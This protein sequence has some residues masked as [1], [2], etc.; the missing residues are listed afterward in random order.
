MEYP[1]DH[2]SYSAISKYLRCPRQWY[3]DYVVAPQEKKEVFVLLLGT[4]YHDALENLYLTGKYQEGIDIILAL[5]EKSSGFEHTHIDKTVTCYKN[6]YRSIYP[7]YQTRVQKVELKDN[8]D[9]AGVK[10]PLEYR[11]DLVTTDGV[12]VDHKTVGQRAP[13]IRYSFQFDLYSYAYFKEYGVMPRKVEYHC[14]YKS[15][16][17]VEVK[18]HIPTISN[19]LKAVDTVVGVASA[20]ENDEVYPKA[21]KACNWCPHKEMCD[22]EFGLI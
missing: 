20:I 15:N 11:M 12:I 17:A 13:D 16:G 9:I 7:K 8:V 19:M 18:D 1:R 6:Y 2:V 5:K 4:A 14:A 21:G 22:R 3:Y 10:I